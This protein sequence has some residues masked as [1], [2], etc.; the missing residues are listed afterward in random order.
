MSEAALMALVAGALL[1]TFTL[2]AAGVV[3]MRAGNARYRKRLETVSGVAA[4]R[5]AK[6]GGGRAGEHGGTRRRQI[7]GKLKELEDQRKQV[8]KKRILADMLI[9]A[10]LKTTK[11]QFYIYS[12]IFAVVATVAYVVMGY[13]LYGALPVFIVGFLGLPRWWLKR[14]GKKR[15][16][17]F[18]KHF[19][20]AVDVIVRGVQSGLPVN[21]CLNILAREAPSPINDEFFQIVEGIKIGQTLNDVLD[22]GLKRIPITEYKFFA[23]VMAIQQQTGGNLAETL[24]GLSGVLRERKKMS[25]QIKSM[26]AEARTTAMIIG[27]LPFCMT[28]LMTLTSYS[29]ISILWQDTMGQY[30]IAGGVML[31]STGTFIMNSM[32]QFDI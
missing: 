3:M 17:N 5:T 1:L 27:S 8:E 29:Y 2:M 9:E 6:G 24:S 18:T 30:M 32:I 13:P 4:R 14:R 12:L 25:D 16:K 7:Q 28:A 15:Q 20:N 31:I 22:R 19:A 11:K 10:N 26:T 21:E 23:I